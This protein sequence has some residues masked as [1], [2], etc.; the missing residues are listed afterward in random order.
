MDLTAVERA[1]GAAG[2]QFIGRT[3][4]ARFL[5]ALETGE[6]LVGKQ[7]DPSTTLESYL[8]ARSALARMLDPRA[9]GAFTVLAFGRQIAS[10]AIRGFG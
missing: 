3:S 5:A 7:A 2:L 8:G 6:L 9:T 4:Q 1:A 10:D